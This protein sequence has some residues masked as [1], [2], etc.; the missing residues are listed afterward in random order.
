MSD[1]ISKNKAECLFW[2]GRYTQRVYAVLHFFRKFRDMLIEEPEDY[3][4]FCEK[5]GV[6]DKYSSAEDF[7]LRYLFSKDD[8]VSLRSALHNAFNNAIVV[9]ELIK[10]ET[11]SYVQLALGKMEECAAKGSDVNEL[12]ELTDSLMAFWGAVDE[13]IFQS[14]TR[15]MIKAGWFLEELDL[16]IRFDYSFPRLQNMFRR[17]EQRVLKDTDVFDMGK[18]LELKEALALP[19]A[20]KDHLLYLLS[21]LLIL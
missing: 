16:H 1:K 8:G 9:R 2:L 15:N 20:A 18:F 6:A 10:S 7:M 21:C 14:E 17:L 5:L 19:G 11:F 13:R 12:Q 4:V 3:T